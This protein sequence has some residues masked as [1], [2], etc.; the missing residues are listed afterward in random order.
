MWV[1]GVLLWSFLVF[2]QYT[3]SWLPGSAPLAE[4][5]AVLFVL[6]ATTAALVLAVRRSFA[7]PAPDRQAI[8]ARVI[9]I[10]VAAFGLWFAT[11]FVAFVIG[12]ASGTNLDMLITTVLLLASCVAV[13][14]GRRM[15]LPAREMRP[16]ATPRERM[17][18]V[19]LWVG[20]VAMTLGA[21]GELA[22]SN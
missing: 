13:I 4:G 7:A 14:Q 3:T 17:F 18:G 12:R 6:V 10:G 19:L 11:V 5:A 9:N 8:A 1:F 15:T 22:G 21:C 16:L 20:A 2:G